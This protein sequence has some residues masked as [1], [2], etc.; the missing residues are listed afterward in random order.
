[1]PVELIS[2]QYTITS[3]TPSDVITGV[4][5]VKILYRLSCSAVSGL[6][7]DIDTTLDADA[8]YQ[9]VVST[10]GSEIRLA[11]IANNFEFLQRP[12]FENFANKARLALAEQNLLID[13]PDLTGGAV[14]L[15]EPILMGKI[16]I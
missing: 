11:R 3:I 13:L 1:M 7:V 12:A 10:N 2:V 14:T 15:S 16:E 6:Y 4:N 9:G 8:L 5:N